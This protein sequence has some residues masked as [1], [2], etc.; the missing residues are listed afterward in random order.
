M[1]L[2]T[3]NK[4]GD[5]PQV[6]DGITLVRF[7]DI[8]LK[9]HPDWAGTDAFG[10]ADDGQRYHF[11]AT[12]LDEDGKVLYGEDDP[13]PIVLEAMT[14][15]ATGEKSNFAKHLK[16]IL[17]AKEFILWQNATEDE[18]FD[19]EVVKGRILLAEV[20]HNKKD[21]PQIEQFL[22]QPKKAPKAAAATA[23]AE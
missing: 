15:T 18:P 5:A 11:V 23:E 2:P 13:E 22:G 10:K 21:W 1:K 12:L 7:D 9:A 8:L 4:G 6:E 20:S 19:G 14:R 3:A 16:G 17:T